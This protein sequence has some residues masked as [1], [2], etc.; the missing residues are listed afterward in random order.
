MDV[1]VVG[2]ITTAEL[3][4]GVIVKEIRIE[5]TPARKVTITRGTL[6]LH[7]YISKSTELKS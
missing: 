2:N 5:A 7:I 3:N 1:L 4:F 6:L